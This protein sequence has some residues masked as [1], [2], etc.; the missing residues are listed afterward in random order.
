[1]RLVMVGPGRAGG[2]L[3]LAA[4]RAGHVITGVLERT[5][6]FAGRHGFVSLS[7]EERLPN[8]DLLVLSV[9]DRAIAEVASRLAASVSEVQSAVHLSGYASVATLRPLEEAGLLVGSFHPLQTLPNPETGAD[10]LAGAYAAV[11]AKEPLRSELHDLASDLDMVPFDLEDE[12][13]PLYHAGAAAASNLVVTALAIAADL[14][15]AAGVPL[16]A[17]RPLTEQ[18]VA[19]AFTL[20]PDAALTGPIARGDIETVRGHLA[21]AEKASVGRQFRLLAEATALRA[22]RELPRP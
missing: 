3:A 7:W 1:M 8:A 4:Q 10:S 13:K 11:T 17:A 12:R 15:G 18:V 14:L 9:S 21:A 16:Q 19:N 22:G 20:G 6:G 2:S 5:G